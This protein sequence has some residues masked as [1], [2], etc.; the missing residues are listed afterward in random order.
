MSIKGKFIFLGSG[1]SMGIPIIGCECL[2]CTSE[3]R[4][5]KRLRPSALCKIGN[6]NILIDC[7]PDFRTQALQEHLKKLD[8]VIFTHAHHDHTA[9]IDELRIFSLRNQQP[10]PCL[11]S[12]ETAEDIKN[13]FH[14]LFQTGGPYS[15]ATPRLAFQ[16]FEG[17]RGQTLFQDIIV[18][19]FSYM[20]AGMTVNGLRFGNLA[21][22]TDI[23][24]YSK[25]ILEDLYGVDTLILSALRFSAS[26]VHFNVDEAVEFSQKVGAKQTWLMH[27]SHDLDHDKGNAYLPEN[28]R[29]AY[30][31]LQLEFETELL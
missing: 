25:Q 29:M 7:G 10:M 24:E 31:G 20:Q 19:Y 5:N 3:S 6:K 21:Y 13:R 26:T 15:H 18:K 2:V 17:D 22:V 16:I 4:F 14:Y 27:T 1:G 8:G 12:E 28:V 23:K 30:D 11:L 9:G